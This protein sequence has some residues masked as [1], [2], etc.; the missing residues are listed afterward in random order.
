MLGS[1]E[2]QMTV[3]THIHNRLVHLVYPKAL[4]YTSYSPRPLPHDEHPSQ[5]RLPPARRPQ[6]HKSQRHLR[7]ALGTKLRRDARGD[8]VGASHHCESRA[9]RYLFHTVR[10]SSH[11][12]HF[13]VQVPPHRSAETIDVYKLIVCTATI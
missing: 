8:H 11:F 4:T 9:K 10:A 13:P 5:P 7:P 1:P 2:A 6:H 3:R 12:S